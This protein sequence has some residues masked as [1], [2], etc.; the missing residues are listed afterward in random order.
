MADNDVAAIGRNIRK[1]REDKGMSAA[2]LAEAAKI[3]RSYLSELE[4]NK[5]DHKRPSA[6]KLY[7]IGKAL[8][9]SMSEL[10]G[11]PLITAR[12][13]APPPPGLTQFAVEHKLPETDVEMLASIRFRGDTP[14]TAERWSFIYNAIKNS[15]GMDPKPAAS[16]S[17]KRLAS[18]RTGP[19]GA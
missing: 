5:G 11:R 7:A 4:N 18:R 19:A 17:P 6:D 10:L 16:R 12:S 9:V 13:S 14:Q 3:S 1:F 8:G 15:A 2:Q